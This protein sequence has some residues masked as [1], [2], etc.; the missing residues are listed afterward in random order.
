MH[1][2]QIIILT[3]ELIEVKKEMEERFGFMPNEVNHLFKI[4]ELRILCKQLSVEKFD[5]GKKG[6]TIK[7]RNNKFDKTDKLI[8]FIN[9]F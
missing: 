9:Q 4:T 1:I 7:F 6:L 2:I 3:Y 5:L 8:D